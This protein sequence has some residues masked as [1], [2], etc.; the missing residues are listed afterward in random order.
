MMGY[1]ESTVLVVDD[2]ETNLDSVKS[3]L[4]ELGIDTVCINNSIDAFYFLQES[5]DRFSAVLL[6]LMMPGDDGL[7]VLSKIKADEKIK[8]IPVIMQTT[9]VD[10]MNMLEGLSAGAHYYVAKPCDKETLVSIVSTAVRDYQHYSHTKNS[11]T[12]AVEPLGM[13]NKG[14]FRFKSLTE[15]RNVAAILSNACPNSDAVILGLTE[16]IINAVEHGN[17]GIGYDEKTRLNANN[18]W[19]KEISRRLDL[20]LNKDKYVSIEF[21]RDINEIK[22]LI[23]D[24]GRGFDWEQYMEISPK[25][26]FDSHG[27][28]I[29]I[30]N[31]ISFDQLEYLDMGNKVSVTV[32]LQ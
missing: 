30:A 21:S 12:K 11:L 27:R 1:K 16:L 4:S 6:D 2:D 28:G 9:D 7:N 15:G 13:M 25:R 22:F 10:N 17:L 20:P 3:W 24:Q 29:A 8:H 32:S 26:I 31:S 14:E 23:A 18:E 19:E 5:P